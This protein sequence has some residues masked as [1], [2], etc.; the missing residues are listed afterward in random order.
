MNRWPGGKA[1]RW[2]ASSIL[3]LPRRLHDAAYARVPTEIREM[4]KKHVE[5]TLQLKEH[6]HDNR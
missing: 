4:V 1:P 6:R 2:Y 3:G 5:H